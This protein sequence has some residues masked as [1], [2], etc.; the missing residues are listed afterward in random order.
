MTEQGERP[1]AHITGGSLSKLRGAILDGDAQKTR[2]ATE[3]ALQLGFSID[4]IF[5]DALLP[6]MR[7]V[8]EQLGAKKI[9]IPD[10]LLSARA[11]QGAM[12]ALRPVMVH[13]L[14]LHQGTVVIGTVAGDLHDIGKNLVAMA[15]NAKGFSVVD[16]GIDVAAER[17]VEAVRDIN[18]DIV[19]ISAMLSTTISEIK[20]VID[21]ICQAG[22]RKQV[23]IMVGGL[24]VTKDFARQ[25][26][27][28]IYAETLFEA[29][30]A[31]DDLMAHRVS[32]YSV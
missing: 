5:N 22:L 13:A 21:A 2:E 7:Q 3:Q 29:A 27:A 10:V 18:P 20:T 32:R 28:D 11:I 6:T 23:A 25:V 31:A 12:Y 14:S 16:L 4:T 19:A 24:S 17:F 26:K 30:E 1:E 9:F 15:L 8:G